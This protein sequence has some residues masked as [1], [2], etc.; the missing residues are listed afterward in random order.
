MDKLYLKREVNRY[1]ISH[2]KCIAS[3]R[4]K[5]LAPLAYTRVVAVKLSKLRQK[6]YCQQPQRSKFQDTLAYKLKLKLCSE[7]KFPET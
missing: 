3:S 4:R 5:N 1:N 2:M 6:L 7:I